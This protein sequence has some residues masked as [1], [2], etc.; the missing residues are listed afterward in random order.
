LS[1]AILDAPRITRDGFTASAGRL[2]LDRRFRARAIAV[3]FFF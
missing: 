3:E 1:H 2:S